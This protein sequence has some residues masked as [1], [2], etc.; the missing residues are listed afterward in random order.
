MSINRESGLSNVRVEMR[1][2]LFDRLR[3]TKCKNPFS[4]PG[5]QIDSIL[6]PVPRAMRTQV[7]PCSAESSEVVGWLRGCVGCRK[8]SFEAPASSETP[9]ISHSK[10]ANRALNCDDVLSF[11]ST[12]RQSK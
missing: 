9:Q 4:V 10:T 11:I 8:D 3:R 5:S 6:Q 1:I 7:S 12:P 2:T